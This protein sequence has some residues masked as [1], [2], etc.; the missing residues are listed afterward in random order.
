VAGFEPAVTGFRRR[1][2]RQATPH[3][4]WSTRRVMLPPPPA[5][6]AGALAAELRVTGTPGRSRTCTRQHLG[7]PPL[8]VGLRGRVGTWR[9]VTGGPGWNSHHHSGSGAFTERRAHSCPADPQ[10]Y[11]WLDSNQHLR[12]LRPQPLPVGL[13]GRMVPSAGYDPATS[14][15][16]AACAATCA[17]TGCDGR[18][19]IGWYRRRDS[20]PSLIA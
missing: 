12:C 8:P 1:D 5:C 3:C 15:V 6:E 7:L 14:R 10:W 18:D 2:V 4:D 19:A 17:T 20:N 16:R 9:M 11:P 13:Q